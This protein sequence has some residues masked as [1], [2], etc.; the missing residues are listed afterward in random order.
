MAVEPLTNI[1]S[2]RPFGSSPDGILAVLKMQIASKTGEACRRTTSHELLGDA[3]SQKVNNAR[4]WKPSYGKVSRS[5]PIKRR[6]AS[7][8]AVAAAGSRTFVCKDLLYAAQ[9]VSR[10][11][12]QQCKRG[13]LCVKGRC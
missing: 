3:V 4:L 9:D 11:S 13:F 5:G 10:Y 1:K 8:A 2:C 7:A 6:G 12:P